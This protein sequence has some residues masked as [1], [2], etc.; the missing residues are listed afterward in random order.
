MKRLG[1]L[2]G[3]VLALAA[4][5]CSDGPTGPAGSTFRVSLAG[6]GANDRAILLEV[7]GTDTSAHIDTVE[8]VAGSPY[9]VFARRQTRTR[10]RV[11]VAGPIAN[12]TLIQLGVPAKIDSTLYTG[13][14]L[15]VADAAFA[16]PAPG[17]RALTVSP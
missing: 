11:I 13:T 1:A 15:D 9:Q 17:A 3:L 10:W 6:V 14:V 4:S 5:Y 7:A 12:G 16:N 8:A 2:L